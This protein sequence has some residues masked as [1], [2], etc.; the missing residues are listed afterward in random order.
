MHSSYW[1]HPLIQPPT[2]SYLDKATNVLPYLQA[3]SHLSY[4]SALLLISSAAAASPLPCSHHNPV[5]FL[6]PPSPPQANTTI[7]TPPNKAG[8]P[9]LN[10]M[11]R[12][13][14]HWGTS[15]LHEKW[16]VQ[17]IPRPMKLQRHPKKHS[18]ISR[19]NEA[20][21]KRNAKKRKKQN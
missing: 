11:R 7:T 17:I 19:E 13:E 2:N 21:S 3:F 16:E 20:L 10:L 4:P 9:V 8:Q 15:L 18:L 5:L 6:L 1:V 12:Q 14:H